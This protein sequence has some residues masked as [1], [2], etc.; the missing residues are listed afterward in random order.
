[1][2]NNNEELSIQLRLNGFSFLVRDLHSGFVVRS[3]DYQYYS[4]EAVVAA[5]YGAAGGDRGACS[6]VDAVCGEL[7]G[8]FA[9]VSVEWN[10]A[11][12]QLVPAE[13][14]DPRIARDYMVAANLVDFAAAPVQSTLFQVSAFD[15][16]HGIS[17]GI[18][19]GD[20]MVA[21]WQ[22]EGELWQAV[23]SL[24]PQAVHKHPLL[25]K[26]D[27]QCVEQMVVLCVMHDM[28]HVFQYQN[29]SLIYGESMAFHSAEELLFVV[30]ALAYPP[31]TSFAHRDLSPHPHIH[32]VN[33]GLLS[34]ESSASDSAVRQIMKLFG[35]HFHKVTC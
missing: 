3:G 9:A 25:R 26:F 24:W 6:T 21:V 5:I 18:S 4:T 30:R 23:N 35:Q 12:A 7:C 28:V 34:C 17:S 32:V 31:V 33:G 14:F 19:S 13:F 2:Y 10:V 27:L 15:A 22:A 8:E 16:L 20:E 11:A 29:L 1:M